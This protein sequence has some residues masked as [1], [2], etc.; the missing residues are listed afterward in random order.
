MPKL[1]VY[2]H[3]HESH[4]RLWNETGGRLK[5]RHETN[6][7]SLLLSNVIGDFRPQTLALGAW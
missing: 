1:V 5:S 2:S 7:D 4:Y 3:R 6:F